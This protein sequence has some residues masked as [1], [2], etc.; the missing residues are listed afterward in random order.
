[1]SLRLDVCSGDLLQ[2]VINLCST[3][4]FQFRWVTG[5]VLNGWCPTK[6]EGVKNTQQ[7]GL[8]QFST[9]AVV[10]VTYS[11]ESSLSGELLVR[12]VLCRLTTQRRISKLGELTTTNI[13]PTVF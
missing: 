9:I 2:P 12:F 11:R 13:D 8:T 5:Q 10:V 6:V 1:M 7:D 4:D 3:M